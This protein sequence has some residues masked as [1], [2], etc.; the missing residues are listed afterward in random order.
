VRVEALGE[1]WIL[2]LTWPASG[3]GTERPLRV[4]HVHGYA[5]DLNPAA[6][7]MIACDKAATAEVLAS[8]GVA[9]VPHRLVLHPSMSKF[10]PMREGSWRTMLSAFEEWGRDVVVK[11]NEGTGGRGVSRCTS[12]IELER[13]AYGLL[14]RHDSLAV[15]PYV[16]IAS[17]TRLVVLHGA[18]VLAYEKVRATVVGDGV[19]SVLQLM[20]RASERAHERARERAT[21]HAASG[22]AHADAGDEV[23]SLSRAAT[24]ALL[25]NLAEDERG[26]LTR[27]PAVGAVVPLNWRHNL[28]QGATARVLREDS[29]ELAE[30]VRLA[31]AAA[32]ALNLRFGSVDVVRDEAGRLRILEINSGVMMEFLARTLPEGE[33]IARRV[34][35]AA[36]AAMGE[37]P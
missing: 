33:A 4:R 17:E 27:V 14:A 12:V 19:H 18:C 31:R 1:G 16:P 37:A 36:L 24:A 15:C 22:K 26:L 35:G 20:T 30:H 3:A 21:T 29:A 32:E 23:G 6:T 9:C 10:V 28:G 8:A 13:A 34:Y 7:H 11:E 25:E 2:R 5:F